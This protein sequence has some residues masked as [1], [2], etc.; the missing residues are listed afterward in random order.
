MKKKEKPKRYWN[1]R[2]VADREKNGDWYFSI[3]EVHYDDDIP[4]SWAGDPQY[5]VSEQSANE[6]YEDINCMEKAF[7]KPLLVVYEEKLVP[8]RGLAVCRTSA[9]LNKKFTPTK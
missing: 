6:L 8:M 9:E 1:Y 7:S 5:P 3:R 4:T 2:V